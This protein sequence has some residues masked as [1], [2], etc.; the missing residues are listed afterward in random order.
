L[1]QEA[2][3]GEQEEKALILALFLPIPAPA[4]K[5]ASATIELRKSASTPIS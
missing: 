1:K 5:R 4:Y 3:S 2:R